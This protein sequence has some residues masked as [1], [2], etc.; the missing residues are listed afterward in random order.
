[1]RGDDKLLNE[2][3]HKKPRL[4]IGFVAVLI[5]ALYLVYAIVSQ[6][7]AISSNEKVINDLTNQI[8][9]N[10]EKLAELRDTKES[11]GSDES[12]ERIARDKL[13]LVRPDEKVFIDIA[14]Q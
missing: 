13:G 12:I 8:T 3:T 9:E 4:K 2:K 10:K 1:M 11:Y 6:Q 14:G 5:F 7:A